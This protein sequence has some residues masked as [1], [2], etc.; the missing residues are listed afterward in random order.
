MNIQLSL[1]KKMNKL[2][3]LYIILIF[4]VFPQFFLII[5]KDLHSQDKK[6]ISK[7]KQI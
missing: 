4:I 1:I 2:L 6:K 5:R 7:V 3:K